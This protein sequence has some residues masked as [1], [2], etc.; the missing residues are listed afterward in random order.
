MPTTETAAAPATA[1]PTPANMRAAL[2]QFATGVTVVTGLHGGSPV[3]FTCQAFSS[4]SIEPPLV[5]FCAD[6]RGTA[7]PRIH[8]S[9]RFC[10][11]ILSEGQDEICA[12]FGS[13]SGQK[14]HEL[15]WDVSA[16]QTPALR[17]V[18]MRVHADVH[19]V[20]VA[21][22]HDIVLGMVRELD[23]VSYQPPMVFHRGAF[24]LA[25]Y[26]KPTNSQLPL[27][28]WARAELWG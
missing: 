12:R 19:D 10:V 7:W 21:G 25:Q 22:D 3:G 15:D 24:G 28:T 2:G 17:D 5:L 20:H 14:F 23:T 8:D 26:E 16:W 11:N 4:V 1:A 13:P 27:S 18:L 6:H 9:G